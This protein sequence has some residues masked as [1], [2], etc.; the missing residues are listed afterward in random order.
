MGPAE[1]Q[2]LKQFEVV[3]RELPGGG[4]ELKVRG[5]L[6][7]AT[8]EGFE[9]PLTAAIDS[10]AGGQVAVDF[11]ECGFVDSV[12]VRALVSGAR[13]LDGSGRKLR[14]SGAR[15]QVRD[16]FNLI[17]LDEARSIEFNG[18]E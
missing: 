15:T 16:L 12:G 14:I 10:P 6:D 9:A 18:S 17:V 2:N 5:E 1:Y 7:L 3:G 13:R 8:V 11:S 4:I